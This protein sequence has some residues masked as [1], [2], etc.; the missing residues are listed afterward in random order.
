LVYV[1]KWH[2]GYCHEAY[3]PQNRGFETFFGQYTHVT[4]YYTRKVNITEQFYPE[5][6]GH[7]LHDGDQ[8]SFEGQ[9]EFSTDLYTRKAIEVIEAH[10]H[11]KP[12]FL[13]LA[14]QAA[15]MKVQ[16]PPKKYLN[17]YRKNGKIQQI[18]QD[19]LIIEEGQE[20][21]ALYRAAA[22][23]A[24]DAG[25]QKIVNALKMADL[26]ENSVIV[27]STDNGGPTEASNFPFRGV[28][29]QLY[30]GGIRGLAFVH[31]P[32]LE[33]KE[34]D[35]SRLMYI[36]DWFSTLLHVANLDHKIPAGLDSFN[37]WPSISRRKDSPRKEIILNLDQDTFW[38]TWS[39]AIMVGKYKFIWGQSYLLKQRLED[40]NN[41]QQLYNLKRDP[42]ERF[43]EVKNMVLNAKD[44]FEQQLRNSSRRPF[45]AALRD[46]LMN[47]FRNEM[48]DA[49]Y[50]VRYNAEANPALFGGALSP[51]WCKRK[52]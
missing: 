29:E 46:K 5:T 4:D 17:L 34:K 39:A 15:H 24:M 25:V 13:Y 32:L 50:P 45:T 41:Q 35:N 27:F 12:L 33:I 1:G 42:M 8:P 7:D 10:K 6:E 2:L 19:E 52:S 16:K 26:Y 3:L 9:N 22:I 23:S 30:E 44:L 40:E 36:T 21:Q 48:V 51:G 43:N 11:S 20:E 38:N 14:F 49:D 47:L 31:S 28:K 18:Y 37:M